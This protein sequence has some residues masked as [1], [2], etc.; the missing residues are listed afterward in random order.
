[1]G[2]GGLGNGA[3]RVISTVVEDSCSSYQAVIC[4]VP[5]LLRVAVSVTVAWPFALVFALSADNDPPVVK[6]FTN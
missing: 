3:F 1:M 4:T 6:N 5:R 2:S